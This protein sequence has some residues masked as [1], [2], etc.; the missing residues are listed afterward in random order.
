MSLG[1]DSPPGTPPGTLPELPQPSRTPKTRPKMLQ[2]V[3]PNDPKR[4]AKMVPESYDAYYMRH[5]KYLDLRYF[6]TTQITTYIP[7]TE[8]KN[9]ISDT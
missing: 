5:T 9:T 2:N 8:I 3:P 1:K 4:K 6:D 7:N